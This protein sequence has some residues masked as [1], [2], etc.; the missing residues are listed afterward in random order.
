MHYTV[1]A[2]LLLA[3]LVCTLAPKAFCQDQK[4][5]DSLAEVYKY[6]HLGKQEKLDVL[7]R[8]SFNEVK[9]FKL[10]LM[11]ADQL[12]S[13]ATRDGNYKYLF[14]GYFQKGNKKRI[15]GDYQEALD[16]YFKSANAARQANIVPYEA[17]AYGAVGDVYA[18]AENYA[19][20]KIYYRKAIDMLRKT[21]DSLSLASFILNAGEVYRKNKNFDSAIIYFHEAEK[22]FTKIN[23]PVGKAYAVGNIG[24]VYA[25]EGRNQL[26]EKNISDAVETLSTSQDYYPV[27]DYFLTLSEM[28]SKNGDL[29]KS[30]MYAQRSLDLATRFHLKEQIRNANLKLSE[31]NEK[32]G[33]LPAALSNYKTYI[34]YRDS[35]ISTQT[36]QKMANLEVAQKQ[37]EVNSLERE[38]QLLSS[39]KT[40]QKTLLFVSLA[41]LLVI[42]VL[43]TIL[44]KNYRQ[45]LRAFTLL[46]KEK[47]LSE[48]QRDQTQKALQEL[49]RTQAHLIHAEKMA[50]LGELTAGIAHEIQNPLN[51][52]NNFSEVNEDL[53]N[54][55]KAENEKGNKQIVAS[56]VEELFKN[57]EK[58][59]HHGKRA[60]AIVK[61]MLQHSRTGLPENKLTDLNALV[62]EYSRL[63]Y[64]GMRAKDQN[65]KVEMKSEF[66]PEIGEV[67]I[68]P[69]EIARV[70]LNLVNNAFYAASEK[71]KNINGAYQPTITVSTKK[72]AR[73]VLISIKDNGPGIPE[74]VKDKIFHPFFTTKAPG[75]G[76]G[77]GLS[78]S[79][80]IVKSHGGEIRFETKENEG[81]EFTV[82]LP[83]E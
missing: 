31:V 53:L 32:A 46:K 16:Y 19:S 71:S 58:I 14:H 70:I 63:G 21:S 66:D 8:L 59:N 56:L 17:S 15:L 74:S 39:Q 3:I 83:N 69:Q 65:S 44:F 40:L 23:Y 64:H 18:S 38:K 76:T 25:E 11:Y 29:E 42:I 34:A 13:L 43:I 24:M 45:K 20:A 72:V 52:V 7:S 26:A 49:K 62:D 6:R 68:I 22:L 77:L 37:L 57:E 4:I 2:Y 10:S 54:E 50:S 1:K 27:C 9:D 12:I 41:I 80:D 82:V 75:F 35:L 67:N 73:Q 55:L 30:L 33:N 79:Y 48:D 47:R 36:I 81:S 51:F 28:Y 60:E 5:A 61:G 78:L